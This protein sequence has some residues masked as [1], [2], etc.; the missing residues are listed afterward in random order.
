MSGFWNMIGQNLLTHAEA[1]G[2]SAIALLIAGA[3]CM[4][5][6]GS[7]FSLLTIYTWL[8]DTVQAVI[9]VPRNSQ[10]GNGLTQSSNGTLNGVPIPIQPVFPAPTDTAT[11]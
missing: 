10:S 1:Y 5:K 11:K 9:P 8:Y 7:P 3:K 4:P 2:V 6:P